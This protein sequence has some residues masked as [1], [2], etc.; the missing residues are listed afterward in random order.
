MD[1]NDNIILENKDC[2]DFLKD[3]ENNSVNLVLIDPSL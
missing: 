3:I 2:F 1:L